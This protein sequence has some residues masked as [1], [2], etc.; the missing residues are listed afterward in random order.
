[1]ELESVSC[2]ET[3]GVMC[4]RRASLGVAAFVGLT[5][6][7]VQATG[8]HTQGTYVCGAGLE[9][10]IGANQQSHGD[11][12]AIS[13]PMSA[14]NL[15]NGMTLNL[16]NTAT[17]ASTA[18]QLT[19]DCINT[20]PSGYW[21][22]P[23][24][25][26]TPTSP[27]CGATAAHPTVSL[28][29]IEASLSAG[30]FTFGTGKYTVIC[31]GSGPGAIPQILPSCWQQP[32][33]R[34]STADDCISWGYAPSSNVAAQKLFNAC[35]HMARADYGGVGGLSATRVGTWVEPYD[36]PPGADPPV[37]I[38]DCDAGLEAYWDEMG[39]TCILHSRWDDVQNRLRTIAKVPER[40]L[41]LFG[42]RFE[43]IRNIDNRAF[44]CRTGGPE[45]GLLKDR[46]REY[47]CLAKQLDIRSCGYKTGGYDPACMTQCP[48]P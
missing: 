41:K 20:A 19:A 30:T 4:I 13:G 35:V 48:L 29:V 7:V 5:A 32:H 11:C 31:G 8:S 46:S 3:G 16:S 15:V 43:A 25:K 42:K 27:I 33:E 37:C 38:D 2:P 39:A 18:V 21:T 17:G 44:N 6:S 34:Y 28:V 24:A 40:E 36:G 26:S 22:C 12:L 9:I 1:V 45:Q 10:L 14:G 47:S 23:S